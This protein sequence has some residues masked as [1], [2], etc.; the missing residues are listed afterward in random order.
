MPIFE[1]FK[2]R[3]PGGRGR[4]EGSAGDLRIYIRATVNIPRSDQEP[5]WARSATAEDDSRGP[6]VGYFLPGQKYKEHGW[7]QVS[8]NLQIESRLSLMVADFFELEW[9]NV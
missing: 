2:G 1:H 9:A 6:V 5:H 4:T 7:H 3:A 8:L